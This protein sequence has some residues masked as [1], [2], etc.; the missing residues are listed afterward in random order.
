MTDTGLYINYDFDQIGYGLRYG[1]TIDE[2]LNREPQL[3]RKS[4]FTSRGGCDTYYGY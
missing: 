2:R 4:S 1:E 3:R